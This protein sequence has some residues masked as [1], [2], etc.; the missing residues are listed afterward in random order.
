MKKTISFILLLAFVKLGFAATS[1]IETILSSGQQRIFLYQNGTFEYKVYPNVITRS[2][3]WTKNE[4][5]IELTFLDATAADSAY[6]WYRTK[7]IHFQPFI[8]QNYIPNYVD[9]ANQSK[10]LFFG[11]SWHVVQNKTDEGFLYTFGLHNFLDGGIQIQY[12]KNE[13]TY[14]IT[15]Y[16][17][18]KKQKDAVAFAGFNF[19]KIEP[20]VYNKFSYQA[21]Y[22]QFR[23]ATNWDSAKI[24]YLEAFKFL[25]TPIALDLVNFLHLPNLKEEQVKAALFLLALKGKDMNADKEFL[26]KPILKEIAG[27]LN[28]ILKKARSY[29]KNAPQRTILKE[30]IDEDQKHRQHNVT[31][32][33]QKLKMGNSDSIVENSLINYFAFW[34]FPKEEEVGLYKSNTSHHSIYTMMRHNSYYKDFVLEKYLDI[35]FHNNNMPLEN[36]LKLYDLHKQRG[37]GKSPSFNIPNFYKLKGKVYV[38]NINE[39]EKL[40]LDS[41][42]AVYGYFSY[43]QEVD[44]FQN[45]Y[46]KKQHY[47][48][49]TPSYVTWVQVKPEVII[50]RL[51]LRKLD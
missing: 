45:T 14:T 15:N 32:L 9:N 50:K 28:P 17:Y 38:Y 39:E 46:Q 26:Y 34:G 2:G 42:R 30:L 7:T 35:S 12:V 6:F 1:P 33:S 25:E 8:F 10:G 47:R 48:W 36:V 16:D 4:Q 19:T 21:R 49:A 37:L 5:D 31:K 23:K 44:V 18:K 40:K 11:S 24:C 13:N 22:Y 51:N 3:T 41:A 29:Q 43:D 27:T 20:V